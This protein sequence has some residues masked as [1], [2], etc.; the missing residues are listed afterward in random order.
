LSLHDVAATTDGSKRAPGVSRST[1]RRLR[2]LLNRDPDRAVADGRLHVHAEGEEGRRSGLP[3]PEGRPVPGEA[4]PQG[5]DADAPSSSATAAAAGQ[6]G[7]E[8]DTGEDAVATAH[9]E[10]V[11]APAA[12]ISEKK[13]GEAT[14]GG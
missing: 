11:P 3:L 14:P 8:D 13:T 5:I 12:E 1:S 4:V 10:N 7:D 6:Q 2:V 9:T